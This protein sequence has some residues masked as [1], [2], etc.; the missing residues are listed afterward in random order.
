MASSASS[1]AQ[2]QG[3]IERLLAAARNTVTAVP[4]CWVVTAADDGGANARVVNAQPTRGPED[5][6]TRWFLTPRVG[7]KAAEI[8]R[9]GQVALPISAIPGMP[10]SRWPGR[11]WST[12]GSGG[13]QFRGS[14]CDDPGASLP[15]A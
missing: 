3:Q 2:Q 6:W 7:R 9:T 8:A 5:F 1:D 15:P 10:M 12:T 14:V 11:G 4:F 13:S